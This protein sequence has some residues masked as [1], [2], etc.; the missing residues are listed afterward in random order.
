GYRHVDTAHDYGTEGAIGKAVRESGIPREEI[1]VTTKLP[2]HHHAK[3]EESLDE[4]LD[5]AGF[6]YYDLWLMHWPQAMANIDDKPNP[7]YPGPNGEPNEGE[8]IMVDSPNLNETWASM[9]KAFETGKAKAIGV[10]NFSAKN[11]RKLLETAK[12]IPAVNQVETH[13]YQAQPELLKL[14]RENGIV[15]TAYAPT[16][17]S[18]VANDP[19]I[20]KLAEKHQVSPAQISLAWHI[21]RGTSAVPKST[22]EGRQRANLLELPTLSE[23]D[24]TL[25]NTLHKDIHQCFYPG[26]QERNGEKLVFGWTYEQMGW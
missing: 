8:Y 5:N 26:V 16:G 6:D 2:L 18:Q 10:S 9:E 21:S 14:C 11:L 17:Y 15:L 12:I 3:V 24:I 1:F 23:E 22:N 13:P 4:C 19:V 7:R 25:I 20:A